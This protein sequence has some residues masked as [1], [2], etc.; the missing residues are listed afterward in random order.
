MRLA[1]GRSRGSLLH[2]FSEKVCPQG[3]S[4]YAGPG[5]VHLVQLSNSDNYLDT[6]EA[7]ESSVGIVSL[8]KEVYL[9][10]RMIGTEQIL[11]EEEK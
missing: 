6:F 5:S 9:M 1:C 4:E 11:E 10:Q 2:H 3:I 7:F 8:V